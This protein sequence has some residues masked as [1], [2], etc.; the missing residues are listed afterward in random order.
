MDIAQ[1]A[2]YQLNIGQDENI[3]ISNCGHYVG[4]YISVS[5]MAIISVG[6]ILVQLK[7]WIIEKYRDIKCNVWSIYIV[8]NI[9]G[10]F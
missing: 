2:S 1:N 5:V 7:Q 8:C 9:Y 6:P 10:I 3:S 4:A